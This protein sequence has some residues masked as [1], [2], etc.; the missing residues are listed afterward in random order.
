MPFGCGP[1][2]LGLCGED[3]FFHVLVTVEPFTMR[4]R[5]ISLAALLLAGAVLVVPNNA[6]AMGPAQQ[7]MVGLPAPPI[8]L[9]TFD[10]RHVALSELRSKIVVVHFAASW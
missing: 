7:P 5:D 4:L 8:D 2:A 1:A 6:A 9:K 10:G 3:D